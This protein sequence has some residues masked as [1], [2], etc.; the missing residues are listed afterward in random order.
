MSVLNFD[1][2]ESKK[3]VLSW[4]GILWGVGGLGEVTKR[5][6]NR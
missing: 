1:L 3:H 6:K 2:K 4:G 5:V